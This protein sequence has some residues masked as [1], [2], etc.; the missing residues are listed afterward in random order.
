MAYVAWSPI[1]QYQITKTSK[2]HYRP[3]GGFIPGPSGKSF[4]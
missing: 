2:G 4:S 3:P 1:P